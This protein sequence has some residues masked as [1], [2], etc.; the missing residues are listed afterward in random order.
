MNTTPFGQQLRAW[1]KRVGLSQVDL[2]AIAE[3]TPR[4]LSFVETGRSRP[5]TEVVLRLAEALGLGMR[6]KN[7]LL[8]AAGLAPVFTEDRF[9][10]DA[11]RPVRLVIDQILARHE[12]YPAWVLQGGLRFI[13]ANTAGARL[14]PGV[15]E[16]GP[17]EL[18]EMWFAPGPFRDLVENWEDVAFELM[19]LLRDEAARHPSEALDEAL[20]QARAHMR[21]VT[22]DV[23]RREFPVVCPILRVGEQR[24]RTIT[25]VLRFDTAA[26]L[27]AESLRVEQMFPVDEAGEAFFRELAGVAGGV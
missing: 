20:T 5:G 22:R 10:D 9:E 6:D 21:G 12:P 7:D 14:L 1:R 23:R 24:I 4:H 26:S 16:F 15:T 18:I 19:R 11:M 13:R 3:T 8:R 25:S 27:G 17:E 2:A